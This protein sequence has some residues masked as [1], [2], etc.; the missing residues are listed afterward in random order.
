M[1]CRHINLEM[2]IQHPHWFT[3]SKFVHVSRWADIICCKIRISILALGLLQSCTKSLIYD[4]AMKLDSSHSGS[5][6]YSTQVYLKGKQLFCCFWLFH[7]LIPY[8]IILFFHLPY[9]MSQ[10]VL[11]FL[12]STL[13][14]L[15]YI[16]PEQR[17]CWGV[18]WFHSVRPSICPSVCPGCRVRSVT[19][20]VLD[21]F[22]PY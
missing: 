3:I 6:I 11:Y 10:I 5:P 12:H 7:I 16:P 21:G 14:L 1:N 13:V 15:L 22:F 4:Y 20:T 19:S 17:S 18:Y 2:S 8:T 9:F